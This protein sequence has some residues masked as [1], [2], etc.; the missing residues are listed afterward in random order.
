[1]TEIKEYIVKNQ[2]DI[3]DTF[4]IYDIQIDNYIAKFEFKRL[5]KNICGDKVTYREIEDALNFSA[6]LS[7]EALKER[8][9]E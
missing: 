7:M 3:R 4:A 8:R 2:T 5:I 1:M 6:K 9:K